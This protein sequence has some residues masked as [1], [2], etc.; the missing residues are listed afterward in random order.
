[1]GKIATNI[2]IVLGVITIVYAGYY[3]Y[4][5]GAFSSTSFEINEQTKKDMLNRTQVFIEHESVLD[6]L[7]LDFSFFEDERLLSLK[8]YST[9]LKTS[10]IGREDPFASV[11][12]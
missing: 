1:M 11:K 12:Q 7:T 2:A 9:P 4:T 6:N 10:P 3:F 8:S 5:Q